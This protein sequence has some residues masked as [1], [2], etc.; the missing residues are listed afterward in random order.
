MT[1][2]KD[3]ALDAV[4]DGIVRDI[5]DGYVMNHESLLYAD[6]R[7]A[8]RQYA[9]RT[10]QPWAV[11]WADLRRLEGSRD[12]ARMLEVLRQGDKMLADWRTRAE[13][14]LE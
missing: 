1:N 5:G 3:D 4:M 8:I 14:V 10:E 12:K 6:T 13:D 9:A 11:L 2:P 7:D